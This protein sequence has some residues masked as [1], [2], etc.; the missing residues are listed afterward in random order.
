MEVGTIKHTTNTFRN[1][2][3]SNQASFSTQS[4]H[5]AFDLPLYKRA[6]G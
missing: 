5:W 1:A 4:V 2:N 6:T 3:F